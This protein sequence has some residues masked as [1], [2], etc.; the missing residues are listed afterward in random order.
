M[1]VLVV[2][3]GR[4]GSELARTLIDAGHSVAVIDKDRR[5]FQRYLPD[6]WQGKAVVGFGFD[7]DHL[8][9][10]GVREAGALAATTGGDNSNILTARIARETYQVTSVVARIQDPRRAVI[11][12]RLGIPTVAQVQWTTDQVLRRMFPGESTVEWADASGGISMLERSLPAAWAGQRLSRVGQ[13]GQFR[14]AAV[15]RAGVAQLVGPD[16]VGQEGDVLHILAARGHVE[17]LEA[18]LDEGDKG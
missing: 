5:A 18:R 9:Q 16:L 11:Y 12:E 8:E 4:V 15:T 6:D 17:D 14:V 10:A 13:Q 2:G 7:R 1:H 3:C